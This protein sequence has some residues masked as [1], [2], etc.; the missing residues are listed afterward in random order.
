[1]FDA[2][3]M[4]R[5]NGNVNVDQDDFVTPYF[6]RYR[7]GDSNE[8]AVSSEDDGLCFPTADL[9]GDGVVDGTDL[10][11]IFGVWGTDGAL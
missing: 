4:D 1:M 5:N 6:P 3:D 7:Q 9:N 10:G 8:D 2:C 11:L